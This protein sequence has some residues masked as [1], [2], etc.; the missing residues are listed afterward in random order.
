MFSP[1]ITRLNLPFKFP[2]T[3]PSVRGLSTGH[4]GQHGWRAWRR[5]ARPSGRCPRGEGRGRGV[6]A[7]AAAQEE[8]AEEPDQLHAGADR[9]SGERSGPAPAARTAQHS[10]AQRRA[11]QSS[12]ALP[13]HFPSRSAGKTPAATQCVVTQL[14]LLLFNPPCQH[15]CHSDCSP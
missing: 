2:V 11:E 6:S 15:L 8:A 4:R 13:P 12:T 3:P 1:D 9:G 10:A 7:E 14:I 5:R